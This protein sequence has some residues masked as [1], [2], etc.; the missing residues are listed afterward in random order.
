M[1][2]DQTNKIDN[3]DEITIIL[4]LTSV[5][6]EALQGVFGWVEIDEYNGKADKLHDK[7][8]TAI[9]EAHRERKYTH[10]FDI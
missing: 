6:A 7:I 2:Y 9:A 5:E 3:V 1:N 8:D 4:K 10:N